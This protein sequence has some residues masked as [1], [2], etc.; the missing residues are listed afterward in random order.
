MNM[1][2][3]TKEDVLECIEKC[4]GIVSKVA[5]RIAKRT[6]GRCSWNTAKKWID[7]WPETIEAFDE[8]I[9]RVGDI[10]EGTIVR[11]MKKDNNVETAK[12]YAMVKLKKRGYTKEI[13]VK[14]V[15]D[16]SGLPEDIKNW[17]V[18]DFKN[19]TFEGGARQDLE[20]EVFRSIGGGSKAEKKGSK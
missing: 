14:T 13:V 18:E 9:E 17:S 19:A 6:N 10:C 1:K 12:W 20:N 7:K 4:E 5:K 3:L 8:E 16:Y 11:S 15:D 2:K